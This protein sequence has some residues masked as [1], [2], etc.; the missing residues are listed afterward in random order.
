MTAGSLSAFLL[1]VAVGAA[2]GLS[3]LLSRY[4]WSLGSILSSV[5]GWSYLLLNGGVAALAYRAALDWGFGDALQG[6]PEHWR[7]LL[8]AVGAMFLLRSSLAQVRF[9]NHEVGIGLVTILEV[10]SR[11]AER[12]LDQVIASQRW[13]KVDKA[14]TELT[15]RATRAYWSAVADTALAS[16]SEAERATLRATFEKIDEMP[17]DDDTKIRLLAMALWELLG[18]KLFETIANEA[19]IRFK[20][21]IEEDRAT[22]SAQLQE[23]AALKAE[24]SRRSTGETQ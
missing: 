12:R 1:A 24:L 11:R 7:V 21:Q 19:S 15:Y 8:V 6:R 23:L 20:R 22:R 14:C 4:R 17:V 13:S 2:V 3:E 18:N 16:Q 5:A 10:F 9:G